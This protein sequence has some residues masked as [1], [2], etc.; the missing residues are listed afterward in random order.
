MNWNLKYGNIYRLI[1]ADE[2]YNG[3]YL[4]EKI[5]KDRLEVNHI[6]LV[7]RPYYS[8]EDNREIKREFSLIK[9]KD[10]RFNEKNKLILRNMHYLKNISNGEKF[11]LES[12]LGKIL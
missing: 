4:G 10:Y 3:L 5:S 11:Y 9:F 12:L 6:I 2:G 8:K 7:N 1:I